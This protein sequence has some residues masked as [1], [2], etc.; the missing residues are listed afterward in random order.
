[1]EKFNRNGIWLLV[2]ATVFFEACRKKSSDTVT[3]ICTYIPTY[4]D[5]TVNLKDIS[6]YS[7]RTKGFVYLRS[8]SRR[9]ILHKVS[10]TE[11]KAFDRASSYK[12]A[13]VGCL[14]KVDTS[15]FFLKDTCSGSKFDFKGNVIQEP[16]I[17]PLLEYSTTFIGSEQLRIYHTG[18]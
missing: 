17:C 14:L 8:G 4:V 7:L 3:Q 18:Q 1:M 16:A 9:I 10:D 2:L 5:T 12:M 13:E 11:Y 6:L 15:A